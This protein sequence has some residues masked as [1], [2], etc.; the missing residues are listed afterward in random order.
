[1]DIPKLLFK[2]YL[3]VPSN[4][5]NAEWF[6]EGD[7]FNNYV[8]GDQVFVDN[9]P[10]EP[11]FKE[12]SLPE[13]YTGALCEK[14]EVDET[15]VLEKFTKLK[16]SQLSNNTWNCIVNKNN[17]LKNAFQFNYDP[18]SL[19]KFNYLLFINALPKSRTDTTLNWIFNYKSGYIT[20]YSNSPPPSTATVEFTFVRYRGNIGLSN[21]TGGNVVNKI[22]T[23]NALQYYIQMFDTTHFMNARTVGMN[24]MDLSSNKYILTYKDITLQNIQLTTYGATSPITYDISAIVLVNTAQTNYDIGT[25]II[26]PLENELEIPVYNNPIDRENLVAHFKCD[27]TNRNNMNTTAKLLGGTFTSIDKKVGKASLMIPTGAS[28]TI[29][30]IDWNENNWTISFWYKLINAYHDGNGVYIMY[31][32]NPTNPASSYFKLKYDLSN[33]KLG[34]GVDDDIEVGDENNI[35]GEWTHIALSKN[36]NLFTLYVNNT[37]YLTRTITI[38]TE[39]YVMEFANYEPTISESAIYMND[40]RIY[41]KSINNY[42]LSISPKSS[43]GI[44]NAQITELNIPAKSI[45]FIKISK[46]EPTYSDE[47]VELQLISKKNEKLDVGNKITFEK[48]IDVLDEPNYTMNTGINMEMMYNDELGNQGEVKFPLKS[49]Y[50]LDQTYLLKQFYITHYDTKDELVMFDISISQVEQSEETKYINTIPVEKMVHSRP[51]STDICFNSH[52]I[53][54][55]TCDTTYYNLYKWMDVSASQD[56]AQLM[57]GIFKRIASPTYASSL[58]IPKGTGVTITRFNWNINE[59]TFSFWYRQEHST[60]KRRN[61]ILHFNDPTKIDGNPYGVYMMYDASN[62][63]L[64]I[65]KRDDNTFVDIGTYSVQM[66]DEWTH[67]AISKNNNEYKFYVNKTEI[68]SHTGILDWG[69]YVVEFCNWVPSLLKTA[70]FLSNIQLYDRAVTP[71]YHIVQSINTMAIKQIILNEAIEL[72]KNTK[73]KVYV[74]P[75]SQRRGYIKVELIPDIPYNSSFNDTDGILKYG[76]IQKTLND[77]EKR[78]DLIS[79]PVNSKY[80]LSQPYFLTYKLK[81]INSFSIIKNNNQ[82]TTYDLTLKYGS[83]S[84]TSNN[85]YEIKIANEFPL[86][87]ETISTTLNIGLGSGYSIASHPENV[88]DGLQMWFPC[89]GYIENYIS[90]V[91]TRLLGGVYTTT[92]YKVGKSSLMLNK[93]SG[94][95]ITQFNWNISKWSISFWFKY[96]STTFIHEIP[97]IWFG[98]KSHNKEIEDGIQVLYNPSNNKVYLSTYKQVYGSITADLN[99]WSLITITKNGDEYTLHIENATIT[100]LIENVEWDSSGNMLEFAQFEGGNINTS[101]FIDD[102]RVYN[103]VL[104]NVDI[105]KLKTIENI[106]ANA[107]CTY[108]TLK[109]SIVIPENNVIIVE[110]K[111]NN[112]S[113]ILDM[114]EEAYFQFYADDVTN[115]VIIDLLNNGVFY[116]QSG[117]K[118]NPTYSFLENRRTGMYLSDGSGVGFSVNGEN[119]M[120][121][122]ANKNISI[123]GNLVIERTEPTHMLDI[124][125]NINVLGK[126]SLNDVSLSMLD[127]SG[128]INVLGTISTTSLIETSDI[129]L[130]RNIIP[131]NSALNKI[132][133]LQG[134]NYLWNNTELNKHYIYNGF[135]AQDVKNHI[136]EV[137]HGNEEKEMLSI[138]YTGLIPYL[139]ES[140]KELKNENDKL[141]EE[142]NIIKNR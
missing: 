99:E 73:I 22:I 28:A 9:I 40:I 31:L 102:I 52:M 50:T 97:I 88:T 86:T 61:M 81:K 101:C 135:I 70:A 8:I 27:G 119:V 122:D 115:D 48:A 17:I 82:D 10:K 1:M 139:V 47:V 106:T 36:D 39:N 41:Y 45:V 15:G 103:R 63:T 134:V 133:N 30:D 138:S 84:F 95:S 104:N 19:R 109:G 23:G 58:Y 71:K 140:I 34:F 116:A 137:V 125:G 44:L 6:D 130:K 55:Y 62:T 85:Q 94:A 110:A 141:K 72:K 21:F 24:A 7:E 2:D 90:E 38:N 20:F 14:Y 78:L 79:H 65:G 87:S 66:V 3:N 120:K 42:D 12:Q 29:T 5:P 49:F 128:N 112:V 53:R 43:L 76:M 131:I 67:L 37:E 89:D 69:N 114:R 33:N 51:L 91:P 11:I 80:K 18:S 4:Q 56:G 124:S 111:R 77:N 25:F 32:H 59:W 142:I 121:L 46:R 105:G 13:E 74:R 54:Q 60:E 26:S 75:H 92:D 107:K 35:F 96:V 93:G 100:Q 117:T 68:L 98:S 83:L 136:P 57:G 127:V 113:Q 123:F 16:L 64:Y 129:R 118:I 126:T 108:Y 132:V